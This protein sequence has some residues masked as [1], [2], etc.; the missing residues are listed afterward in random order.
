MSE[1]TLEWSGTR[2]VPRIGDVVKVYL[3]NLGVGEVVGYCQMGEFL[4]VRVKLDDPPEWFVNQASDPNDCW[5]VG[6]ELEP[7]RSIAKKFFAGEVTT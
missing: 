7:R 1:Q 5:V 4:G 6:C 3:N 2:G